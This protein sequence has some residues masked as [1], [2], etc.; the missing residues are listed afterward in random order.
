MKQK[1]TLFIF[2]ITFCMAS[3]LNSQNYGMKATGLFGEGFYS[4]EIESLLSNQSAFT[5]EFWYQIETFKANKWIFSLEASNSN[6]IGILTAGADNGNVY[7]RV[8]DGTNHGQQAFFTANDSKYSGGSSTGRHLTATEG[9]W[10]HVAL[11]FDSG[12]V[13]LYIDGLELTGQ[14]IN[15]TYPDTTG[16]LSGKDFQIAWDT[17]ANIDE[18]RI[19]K[20][21]ALIPSPYAQTANGFDAYFSFD[22]NEKPAGEADGS[23]ITANTGSDN[24]V[25]GYIRNQAK[26]YLTTDNRTLKV[27]GFDKVEALELYPNPANNFVKMRLSNYQSGELSIFTVLGK[28]V[29]QKTISN[30]IEVELNTSSLKKGMYILKFENNNVKRVSKLIIK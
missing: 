6:R 18:V 26:T 12:V 7:V 21:V 3:T 10:N 9:D 2:A 5:I 15:G 27:E 30:Q 23:T 24:S 16:D 13:K 19:T 20:G 29:L 14:W 4:N 25:N 11:T 8:G 17:E 1:I 28:K 22:G